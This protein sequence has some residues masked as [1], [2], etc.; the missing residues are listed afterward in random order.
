MIRTAASSLG[1]ARASATAGPRAVAAAIEAQNVSLSQR[2]GRG[3]NATATRPA[4]TPTI[5]V[6]TSIDR[7]RRLPGNFV[8]NSAASFARVRLEVAGSNR[9]LSSSASS[10]DGASSFSVL[11]PRAEEEA[12]GD[13]TETSL[14]QLLPPADG[15]STN[16]TARE[17]PSSSLLSTI[18]AEDTVNRGQRSRRRATK[19]TTRRGNRRPPHFL[20]PVNRSEGQLTQP[21]IAILHNEYKHRWAFE[22]RK[23]L[24][25]FDFD[26][27]YS[28]N[29]IELDGKTLY[30][31]TFTCPETGCT[32]ESGTPAGSQDFPNLQESANDFITFTGRS[33]DSSTAQSRN[34]YA[35]KGFAKNAAA[36]RAI[37]CLSL[38]EYRLQKGEDAPMEEG[39]DAFR[40]CAE[41]PFVPQASLSTSSMI[42]PPFGSSGDR[43]EVFFMS[44][45]SRKFTTPVEFI[46]T[47][48]SQFH[49]DLFY[50]I[51]AGNIGSRGS[52]VERFSE[53]LKEEV[54][55]SYEDPIEG[56]TSSTWLTARYTDPVS[57]VVFRSGT[58]P[59]YET[60]VI[61]DEVYYKGKRECLQAAAARAIDCL[62]LRGFR[63]RNGD[64]ADPASDEVFRLCEEE[65]YGDFEDVPLDQRNYS[66]NILTSLRDQRNKKPLDKNDPGYYFLSPHV[67]P[68]TPAKN[69]LHNVSAG[70]SSLYYMTI[71]LIASSCCI[72]TSYFCLDFFLA[73]L[74]AYLR[75]YTATY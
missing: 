21:P 61:N 70:I 65:P 45:K 43:T 11:P 1:R 3:Y 29:K 69:F 14:S 18:A 62:S 40:M 33:G 50:S 72:L 30:H 7:G 55:N 56:L 15:E 41:E 57:G 27:C 44:P 68:S 71:R 49:N 13:A 46:Q 58:L 60:R 31:A 52:I 26:K 22:G 25:N 75:T 54:P 5:H 9:L 35:S 12:V 34:F 8:P 42:S 24:A 36:A 63:K 66:L 38:R 67:M 2:R 17:M 23:D 39:T 19:S 16:M 47:S 4:P 28:F 20:S 10:G 6:A 74:L 48:I 32:F 59:D 53:V 51:V 64:E 73:F 37:D